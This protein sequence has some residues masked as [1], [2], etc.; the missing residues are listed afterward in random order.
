[1]IALID[2]TMTQ[3]IDKNFKKVLQNMRQNLEDNKIDA[4][5]IAAVAKR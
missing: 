3:K 5:G 4:K 2:Q 1:M